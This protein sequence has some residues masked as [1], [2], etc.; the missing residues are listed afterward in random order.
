MSI[1]F[2]RSNGTVLPFANTPDY[3]PDQWLINPILPD[4]VP[5]KYLK[6]VGDSVVE[7]TDQEKALV[8]NPPES[9]ADRHLR[10]QR[11]GVVLENGWRIR[12][13]D[14]DQLKMGLAKVTADMLE[15]NGDTSP[16]VPFYEVDD[17]E[18]LVTYTQAYQILGDY[19]VKVMSHKSRQKQEV[20]G[21]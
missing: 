16:K 17:A 19:M 9:M 21:G 3:P 2:H 18:H 20:S 7:M 5:W 8:D 10:E 4:G 1:V 13:T 11:E 15:K 6:V 12:W 14:N